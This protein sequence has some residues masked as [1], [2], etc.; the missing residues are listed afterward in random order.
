[1]AGHSNPLEGLLIMTT[2]TRTLLCTLAAAT[3]LLAAC[4]TSKKKDDIVDCAFPGESNAPAPLWLCTRQFDGF[5]VT[6]IGSFDKSAAGPNFMTQQAAAQARAD[7]AQQFKVVMKTS[8]KNVVGQAGTGDNATI[9]AFAENVVNQVSVNTLEG[10]R[11]VRSAT[12][13]KGTI[14]VIVGVDKAIAEAAAKNVVHSS[15]NN[16]AAQWQRFQGKKSLAE[17]ETEIAKLPQ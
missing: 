15:M 9:D 10:A 4:S 5:A 6:G 16:Q 8:V 13:P 11:I 14:W 17:L 12:S 2:L 7:I 3:V 1:M